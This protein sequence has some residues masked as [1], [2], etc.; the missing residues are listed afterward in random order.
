MQ[1]NEAV[2]V[3]ALTD[4]VDEAFHNV[5]RTSE[6]ISTRVIRIVRENMPKY[7]KDE[8]IPEIARLVETCRRE[9]LEARGSARMADV[10]EIVMGTS[11]KGLAGMVGR[12]PRRSPPQPQ[13][14]LVGRDRAVP[15][16]D[17]N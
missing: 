17:R 12:I 1:L 9:R 7:I 4:K 14:V 16:G 10:G 15:N 5:P 3:Q 11:T 13:D 8:A 6:D 2:D